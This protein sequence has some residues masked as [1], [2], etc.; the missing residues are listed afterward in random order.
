M[1]DVEKCAEY[2][3][4][5]RSGGKHARLARKG[6]MPLRDLSQFVQ[7]Y[8]SNV[9]M[10]SF[11]MQFSASAPSRLPESPRRDTSP[12]RIQLWQFG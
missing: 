9:R 11:D 7:S 4:F 8:G 5:F 10:T 12:C 2:R 6:P 3:P 1:N